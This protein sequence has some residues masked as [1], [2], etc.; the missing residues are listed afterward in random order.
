M[1]PTRWVIVPVAVVAS[2]ATSTATGAPT[3]CTTATCRSGVTVEV[4]YA[5]RR[6]D[7]VDR[8]TLC[9]D[10]TCR[11]FDYVRSAEAYF[12]GASIATSHARVR[13]VVHDRKSHVLLRVDRRVTL[14]HVAPNGVACGPVCWLRHVRL[15]ETGDKLV[16]TN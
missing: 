8:V 14:K 7:D 11:S 13:L 3:N 9:V 1:Q 6:I 4:Q 15:S 2:L 12:V 16:P 10:K 5:L